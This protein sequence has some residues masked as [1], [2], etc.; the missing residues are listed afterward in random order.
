MPAEAPGEE[1]ARAGVASVAALD[2]AVFDANPDLVWELA[3][4]GTVRRTNRRIVDVLG[5]A[6]DE[7]RGRPLRELQVAGDDGPARAFSAA[8]A[9]R[10]GVY[11]CRMR[12]R[13]GHAVVMRAAVMP[14]VVDGEVVGVFAS[15]QDVTAAVEAEQKLREG[16]ARY[17]ALVE[18]LPECVAMF[19]EERCEFINPA[20]AAMR[21]LGYTPDDVRGHRWTEFVDPEDRAASAAL[22]AEVA[23][24]PEGTARAYENR[25]RWPDGRRV[26]V[27]GTLTAVRLN[28]RPAVH[29]FARDVTVRRRVEGER[30]RA[31]RMEALG[32]LAAGVAHD[33]NNLLAV[34]LMAVE[35]AAAAVPDDSPV[36][37][38]LADAADAARRGR[39]LTRQLLTFARRQESRPTTFALNEVVQG[40]RDLLRRIAGPAV[41]LSVDL[42]P[43]AGAITAD[44][45]QV[46]QVLLNLV[47]NARDALPDGGAVA[48]E[49][50]HADGDLRLTVRDTGHGIA[51][52]VR[53]HLFEPFFTTKQEGYGLGLATVYGVVTGVGGRVEVESAPGEGTA[54]HLYFPRT[55][56]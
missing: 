11:R 3:T 2:R 1:S 15:S 24:A 17:R 13:D 21:G 6:P 51:P 54:F 35:S 12:H 33:F 52:D 37:E 31:Q 10:A 29:S 9:G 55:A 26:E 44:P 5:Y 47:T 49:T 18:Q 40:M 7:V 48:V 46:E 27:E 45:G 39:A 53:P 56:P 8:L 30:L 36:R 32:R 16:E 41:R 23:A 42:A 50:A 20:G 19:A 43:D 28:G 4:N 34:M 14:V 38:D 25:F 22:L